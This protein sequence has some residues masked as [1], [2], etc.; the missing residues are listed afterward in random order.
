MMEII[1]R[2]CCGNARNG[3]SNGTAM[4]PV[5]SALTSGIRCSDPRGHPRFPRLLPVALLVSFLLV[6]LPAV[7]PP[8]AAAFAP[9]AAFIAPPLSG[10]VPLTVQFIDQSTSDPT[11]WS[12]DF[13][14]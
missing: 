8:A 4:I 6:T 9:V 10:P 2:N 7:A 11:T 1:I 12:W 3:S 14:D 13:G 5:F